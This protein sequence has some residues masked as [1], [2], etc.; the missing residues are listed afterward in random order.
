[1]GLIHDLKAL[2]GRKVDIVPADSVHSFI[3]EIVFEEAI[4]L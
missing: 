3:K 1:M 4:A 2:L